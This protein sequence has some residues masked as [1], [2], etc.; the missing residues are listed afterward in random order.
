MVENDFKPF[1]DQDNNIMDF[2]ASGCIVYKCGEVWE[3]GHT[4]QVGD[5]NCPK[6]RMN[7]RPSYEMSEEQMV[8]VNLVGSRR[9]TARSGRIRD[10]FRLDVS[11]CLKERAGEPPIGKS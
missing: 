11:E 6:Q 9:N 4:R 1:K 2:S 7:I 5:I 8:M 10:V 3:L